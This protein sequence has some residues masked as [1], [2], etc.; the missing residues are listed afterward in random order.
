MITAYEH[1][2]KTDLTGYPKS[3]R[4]HRMSFFSRIVA[5]AD[6]FDAATSARVYQEKKAPAE[7]LRELWEDFRGLDPVLVKTLTNLLGI[8]PAGTCVILD[9]RELALVHAANSD[10]TQ[11]HRPTVRIVCKADGTWLR[12]GPLVDLSAT[13]DDGHYV[14]SIM[15]VTDTANYGIRTADYFV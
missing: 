4:P 11:I 2:M 7:V 15:K 10:A 3:V 13:T 6:H 14:R 9:S 8:Y 5:M 1:H 12:T